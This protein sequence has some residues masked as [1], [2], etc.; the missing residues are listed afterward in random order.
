AIGSI[1]RYL[2]SYFL[3]SIPF[4]LPTLFIN[5]GGS[6]L[7]GILI[8]YFDNNKSAD[9][10]KYLLITGFCGGFTTFSTFSL[11]SIQWL[12][13]KEIWFFLIYIISSVTC[14][15]TAT[16]IGLKIGKLFY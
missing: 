15:I 16:F 11:E 5:I 9:L 4:S 14:C 7:I 12:Q 8:A 3:K 1:F 6:L 2:I 10:Y 13:K